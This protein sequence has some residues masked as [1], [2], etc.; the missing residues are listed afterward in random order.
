VILAAGAGSRFAGEAHKLLAPWRGRPLAAWAI[1]H[2]V[3]AGIGPTWLVTGAVDL[4]AAGVVPPG[5]EVLGN[6]Q[7]ARGQ[8]TSLARAV[9]AAETAGL[10]AIVVGLA[11]QP[12]I[13]PE[14]WRAVATGTDAPIAVATYGGRRRNPVRL[15]REVWNL[16]PVTG[17][18]GASALIA[19]RPDL[20][21]AV[22][23]EGDP[24]D[25][26]TLE[27]LRRWS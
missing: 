9:G 11:D 27:D 12:L 15:A 10:D 21:M 7:W 3:A 18:Q 24:A 20:V 25:I 23:C 19:R 16:L 4:V 6:D 22:A 1:D 17:D 26:D 8:A 13:P 5:V 2:A 14:T